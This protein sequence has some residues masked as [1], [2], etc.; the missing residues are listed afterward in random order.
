MSRLSAALKWPW[1]KGNGGA[2]AWLIVQVVLGLTAGLGL[3]EITLQLNPGLLWNG[4]GLPAPA[5]P[6][7]RVQ[8][9]DVRYSDGDLFYWSADKIQPIAPAANQL[10]AHV[11]FETDELGFANA[12]PVPPGV[13]VVV[14]GRSYS[15]GAQAAEAWP[16][17]VARQTGWPV[18][19]LS[20]AGSGIDL[21]AQYLRD[22]GQPRHPRWVV[23]EVLP[24]MDILG[25]AP[26]SPWLLQGLPFALTQRLLRQWLGAPAPAPASQFI[27]PLA[28]DL[29]G[30]PK[31]LTFFSLYLSSLTVNGSVW[32]ASQDWAA[33]RQRLLALKQAAQAQSMCV[34][35]LFAPTKENLY[36][37]LATHPAQLQP[38]L[39]DL[40]PWHLAAGGRLTPAGAPA[41]DIAAMQANALAARDLLAAFAQAND[42]PLADPTPRMQQAA[43]AGDDPFMAYDTHWSATGHQIV[44]QTVVE[45]LQHADCP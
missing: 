28:V 38:V 33:Y 18:L 45:T 21:K 19:N 15:L 42:L 22:F 44:A 35:L 40:Q 41:A 26:G 29:A 5:E 16:H 4:M 2:C 39:K 13:E 43:L 20:Q 7:L 8:D 17:R 12:A 34:V 10:E 23:V 11:H 14:L 24:P 32:A 6:P 1:L 31:R 37:P 27:Y 30:Q 9:Y 25:Y 3:I 36:F